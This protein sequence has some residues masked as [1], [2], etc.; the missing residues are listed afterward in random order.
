[1]PEFALKY[2]DARGEI[3][4]QVMEAGSE[5]EIRDKLAQQGYLVYSVKPRSALG[6]LSAG[7]RGRSKKL[8]VEKF[9]IFNQQFVTLFRA[10]LPILK[11]LDLLGDRLTDPKLSPIVRDI[12]D[13][14]KKGSMLSDAFKRQE[15]FPAIYTTSIMAGEKSGALGEVLER[16]VNYQRLALAVRKKIILS[17]L[18]PSIL[19]TLVILLVIFLITFVVP[20]FASLYATTNA[21][22]PGPTRF[23]MA[24]GSAA[25]NYIVVAAIGVVGAIVGLRFYL[26]TEQGKAAS[27]KVKMRTPILGEIWSKYQVAQL[28]RLL[29]TLLTGGI[30]LVQGMETAAQSVGSP[31][32]RRALA[33]AQKMVKEG[34]PLSGALAST[35]I[36]PPLAIDMIEVGESTG[37]LPAMLNSVAEF[38]EDD[39]NTRMQ[40]SLSLIEP[41]IMIF[42]GCFVAFVLVSLY[43]PIFS[44]ADSFG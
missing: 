20:R 16:Y 2:A 42:M 33:K 12:R 35:G 9:L 41:A 13:D 8:D 36:V 25:E 21:Q 11:C 37:A 15:V 5:Q 22:L 43:L 19:I 27:D 39:V 18:Y 1:M 34:Q 23:L 4:Q 17:L 10:G 31:L 26:R 32:L 6:G 40:A 38:Y 30:P 29:S 24:V 44:L 14:V 3:K 7:L 28:A